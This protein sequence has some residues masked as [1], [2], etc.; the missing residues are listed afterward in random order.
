MCI[1]IHINVTYIYIRICV[2]KYVY[3]YKYIYVYILDS[4]R[5]CTFY[6]VHEGSAT[7]TMLV[8]VP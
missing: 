3:I 4:S 7:L 2:Y 8:K 5:H 6:A 1:Y